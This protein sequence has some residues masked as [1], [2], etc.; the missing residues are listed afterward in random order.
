MKTF[1]IKMNGSSI[2]KSNNPV[3]EITISKKR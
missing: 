1:K 3:K 2:R